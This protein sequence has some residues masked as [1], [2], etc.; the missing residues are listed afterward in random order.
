M[1]F[2]GEHHPSLNQHDFSSRSQEM[3]WWVIGSEYT[4]LSYFRSKFRWSKHPGKSKW[5]RTF[6]SFA[7][8][9][10]FSENKTLILNCIQ[11]AFYYITHLRTGFEKRRYLFEYLCP[12][13]LFGKNYGLCK[14]ANL[15]T[16]ITDLLRTQFLINL[17]KGTYLPPLQTSAKLP[18][19]WNN[20][21]LETQIIANYREIA[22]GRNW[23]WLG[24][25]YYK[26]MGKVTP[27]SYPLPSS[28][29]WWTQLVM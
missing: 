8:V 3:L 26:L 7:N 13:Y 6:K 5:R 29:W 19:A 27:T 15:A 12:M 22:S 2:W 1:T 9:R 14:L 17:L 18:V 4:S 16:L 24:E 11:L 20:Q 21:L 10:S 25:K 28:F 23:L